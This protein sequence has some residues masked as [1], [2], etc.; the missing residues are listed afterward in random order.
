MVLL[1]QP[2]LS[3]DMYTKDELIRASAWYPVG[4][5]TKARV[6]TALRDRAMLLVSTATAF[7]GDNVRSLLLSDLFAR[8]IPMVE[9]GEDRTLMVC[10]F[11][12]TSCTDHYSFILGYDLSSRPG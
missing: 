11:L 9:I 6:Y 2:H 7:R 10:S 8:D 1:Q 5:N 4:A 12:L 3:S